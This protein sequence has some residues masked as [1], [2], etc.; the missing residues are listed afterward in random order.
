L[1]KFNNSQSKTNNIIRLSDEQEKDL[2]P[3]IKDILVSEKS[4]DPMFLMDNGKFIHCNKAALSK[5]GYSKKDQILGLCLSQIS[6]QKQPD[7]QF[8]EDKE[9]GIMDIVER[10]GCCRFEWMF[11]TS[12]QENL[13]TEVSFNL[14]P[15]REKRIAQIIVHDLTK[16]KQ[17]EADLSKVVYQYRNAFNNAVVGMFR[18]A[19]DGRYLN[20]NHAYARMHGFG[21]S[22]EMLL[23]GITIENKIYANPRDGSYLKNLITRYGFV[24]NFKTLLH[25]TGDNE[26][27]IS[28]SANTAKDDNGNIVYYEG[29]AKDISE[30]EMAT[31][32]LYEEREKFRILSDCA[33]FGMAFINDV[34]SLVY[35]NLKFTEI[36][37][38]GREDASN[39]KN[40]FSEAFY[41]R[42]YWLRVIKGADSNKDEDELRKPNN[43]IINVTCKDGRVKIVDFFA[44]QLD[45]GEILINCNDITEHKKTE[46]K[47]LESEEKFRNL[48]EKSSDPTI[49]TDEDIVVDCNESL[50]RLMRCNRKQLIGQSL[51]IISPYKQPD[52]R[53]SSEKGDEIKNI[54]LMK[55]SH[56]F[57]WMHCTLD[58]E[59]MPFDV[60]LTLINISGKPYLYGV[61][62]DMREQNRANE[63]IKAREK[64]L[65]LKSIALKESNVALKIL[66]DRVEEEKKDI[67]DKILSNI[68]KLVWPYIEKMKHMNL[69]TANKTYLNIIENNLH[70]VAA[71]FL[72][73]IKRFDLTPK[74]TQVANLIKENKTTK[75]IAEIMGVA[76]SSIDRHRH[77]IRRKLGLNKKKKNLITYLNSLK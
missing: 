64:E 38:Y 10:E 24:S 71:P 26:I 29:T 59:E 40:W 45:S 56:N 30:Q 44:L 15:V 3:L 49:L 23:S 21:S 52:G 62:R 37:G 73:T 72:N 32:S 8:S 18:I 35:V 48:F 41:D 47:L 65:E 43:K 42:E 76:P 66:L 17:A 6:P 46:K 20:V 25:T 34:G 53:L 33:P 9:K 7:D 11:S 22:E 12:D 54:T 27:W 61:W 63:A 5:L 4:D 16:Q 1:A 58:G 39:W 55:G 51:S 50:L 19:P 13:W 70:E 69:D 68:T 77:N 74:E 2:Y 36:F 67:E 60:M 31:N 28:I 75:K 14:I 57:E